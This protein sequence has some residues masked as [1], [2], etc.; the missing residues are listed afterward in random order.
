MTEPDKPLP[1]EPTNE[2]SAANEPPTQPGERLRRILNSRLEDSGLTDA[3]T[4]QEE[5]HPGADLP[6]PTQ[7]E[8]GSTP[9]DLSST[10]PVQPGT[11]ISDVPEQ[12]SDIPE[13]QETPPETK[14]ASVEDTIP[15]QQLNADNEPAAAAAPP[16]ETDDSSSGS[17]LPG[18]NQS[19]KGT[20]QPPASVS[21]FTAD[22]MAMPPS[23]PG[24]TQPTKVWDAD[25]A[26][27]PPH[28]VNH[29]S[30]PPQRVDQVDMNA[31]RVTPAAYQGRGE[32]PPTNYPRSQDHRPTTPPPQRPN[33]P[34]SQPPSR[35]VYA[36]P[37]PQQ[38]FTSPPPQPPRMAQS[39]IPSR[40]RNGRSGWGCFVRMLIIFIFVAT[41]VVV[42]GS[43][44]AIYQYFSIASSLPSVDDLR[45]RAS[46]FETTRILD[47][48]GN[49][50]YEIIDPSAGRRTHVSLD[51]ISPYLIAATLATEDKDF[52]S[53]PGFDVLALIRS[54]WQNYTIGEIYT[55]PGASTITQQL[56]RMLLLSP[57]ERNQR[58][59]QRKAREIVLAAEITRRYTKEEI[60]EIYLNEI[61][62]GNMSYGIEAAA[63]TYF[64]TTAG[65]L[66]FGQSAFLV[67]LPQA[68]SVYDI[69]TNRD[70][71]LDRF[72][73]VVQLTYTLSQERNC[74][75]VSTTVQPVCIDAVAASRALDEIENYNFV[76]ATSA[77]QSPHWVTY[78]RSLLEAQYDPQTIYRSGFTVYTTLDPGLQDQAEKIVK[79]QVAAL[80]DKNVTDAALVAIRPATGEILAMVGS[81]DFYNDAIA[82]Q[83][84]MAISPRQPGSSIKPL[85]YVAAFEKGWTPATVI[86]DVPSEFPPSGLATDNRPPYKPTNYDNKAHGPVSVR[87]ALSNSYN[88]P[89]VKTLDFIGLYNQG[90]LIPFAKKMGITTLTRQD[91]GLSLT[92]GG[93]EVTPL[94]L[95]SA[96][97]VFANGGRR[98]PPFAISKIVDYTGKTVFEYKT[99]PGEQ[100]VRPEHAFLITSILTDT[101]SRVP[102]FGT[103]PVINLPFPAAVKTGTTNDFHD[104][105]TL[106]Y[107][108]DIAVGVWVGNADYTPMINTTGLTGAAP[109]W[110]DFMKV[111]IQNLTGGNPTPFNRPAGIVERAV[112]AISG[113]EPSQWCPKQRGEY[114]AYDQLPPSKDQDF[115]KKITIDTW[116]GL[117]ASAA[118]G[119]FTDEK[120]AL[121]ISDPW[122]IK[123]IQGTEQGKAWADQNGFGNNPFIVPERECKID[124]PHPKIVYSA[125]SEG[126]SI[127]SSPLDI[128][129]VVDAPDFKD[130]QLSVGVG[131]NNLDSKKLG[132]LINQPA[133][134]PTKIYSLDMNEIPN[135]VFTLVIRLNST[136]DLY[137]AKKYIHLVND[138]PTPT[139]TFTPTATFT[140][141][142]TDTATPTLTPTTTLTST[143]V[144]P[145]ATPSKT[146]PPPTETPTPT[147]TT[148]P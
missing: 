1:P 117:Q 124:D 56:A 87:T 92:L 75:F 94:E 67:G 70:Q 60:L 69:Y 24:S 58:T 103:N 80:A 121:N 41:V 33:Y 22:T 95:T 136:R 86:W 101:V 139:P 104:N 38:R 98:M 114:F 17:T 51:Q 61:F 88:I 119:E 44:F 65:K 13:E 113:T 144:P 97:S 137:Y 130:F 48:N 148:A 53:H 76:Q 109:I 20:S 39:N 147:A 77:F 90:G 125:F 5:Q 16:F 128:Y 142:P 23:E 36:Q 112:C 68:P 78:I 122:A 141:T 6:Q 12:T 62:Y 43:A 146:P 108:P 11:S 91:Y 83:I 19:W 105:W 126:Q 138:V 132:G 18:T 85:T 10:Q 2:R 34:Q 52:Y 57:T 35:P 45:T 47:R 111:A 64:S 54:L 29:A 26:T 133:K 3:S 63:E 81:A 9:P 28:P 129:A 73:T 30:P 89:A 110:A 55:G 116:T 79:Q 8:P 100:V 118:C 131:E 93:G 145:S 143:P 4:Q 82:G 107:T 37:R 66:T 21:P 99:P 14:H 84:N 123:W 72:S 106:G 31:T 134:D 127:T 96:Y 49:V 71:T 46:Q 7:P 40:P 115:W 50:L 135:G 25:A 140:N 27:I 120:L 32:A 15:P 74:I 102:M 42:L 59:V